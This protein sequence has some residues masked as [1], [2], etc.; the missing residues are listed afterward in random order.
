MSNVVSISTRTGGSIAAARISRAA[1]SPFISGIRTSISTTSGR[2]RL[3]SGDRGTTGGRPADDADV[4][5][6]P[7]QR[8]EALP[9]HRLIVRNEYRDRH[10]HSLGERGVRDMSPTSNPP[11]S[12]AVASRVPPIAAARSRMPAIPLPPDDSG[13]GEAAEE[14]SAG[15]LATTRE[16]TDGP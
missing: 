2:S 1:S 10:R 14:A 8:T 7:Q 4:G 11:S 16:V 6:G 15:P 12:L 3:T 13:R 5:L 9:H